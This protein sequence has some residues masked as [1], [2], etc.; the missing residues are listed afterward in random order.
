MEE[1]HSLPPQMLLKA[2][3]RESIQVHVLLIWEQSHKSITSVD[4][5]ISEAFYNFNDSH[6]PGVKC[7]KAILPLCLNFAVVEH[8]DQLCKA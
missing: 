7:R 3:D 2:I 4:L 8:R 1:F 6:D 5:M